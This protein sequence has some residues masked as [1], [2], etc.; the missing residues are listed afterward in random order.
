MRNQT[1]SFTSFMK[2]VVGWLIG[3]VDNDFQLTTMSLE[4]QGQFWFSFFQV[5]HYTQEGRWGNL[6]PVQATPSKQYQGILGLTS[7]LI[8]ATGLVGSYN[9]IPSILK[10]GLLHRC[11]VDHISTISLDSQF[12]FTSRLSGGSFLYRLT[13]HDSAQPQLKANGLSLGTVSGDLFSCRQF[14]RWGRHLQR[15]RSGYNWTGGS[16]LLQAAMHWA[17]SNRYWG[18]GSVMIRRRK[19]V[20]PFL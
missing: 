15:D 5:H 13:Q 14:L 11:C 18:K 3:L 8:T 17:S 19:M 1:Y 2:K 20:E 9:I 16:V 10:W 6:V 7:H 12:G 4:I